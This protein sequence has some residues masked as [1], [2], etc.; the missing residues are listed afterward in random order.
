[1]CKAMKN[2]LQENIDVSFVKDYDK[3]IASLE[4]KGKNL[5]TVP[6]DGNCVYYS[7]SDQLFGH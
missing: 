3:A 1:M 5:E 2:S 7:I 6:R 4:V